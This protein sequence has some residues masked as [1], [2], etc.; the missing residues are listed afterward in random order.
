MQHPLE[1]NPYG[2]APASR[3]ACLLADAHADKKLGEIMNLKQGGKK[4]TK[5]GV[6]PLSGLFVI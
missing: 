4:G 1:H 3:G 2:I 6:I 5:T